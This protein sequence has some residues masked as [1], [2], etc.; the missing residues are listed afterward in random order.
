MKEL[1]FAF[2]IDG[3]MIDPASIEDPEKSAVIQNI[4]EN[5]AQRVGEL[6][7]AE[8]GEAPRF[9]CAGETYNDLTL[10]VQG[11]CE[12]LIEQVKVKLAD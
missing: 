3:E 7:C 4:V 5:I 11:C 2:Y 12:A 10:E 1:A 6:E 8:H 9:V